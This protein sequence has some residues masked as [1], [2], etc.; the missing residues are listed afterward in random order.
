M[1]DVRL[2]IR[3]DSTAA[4]REIQALRREIAQ[5]Q[6]GL[7][8]SQRSAV[9]AGQAVDRLGDEARESAVGVTELGRSIFR[10]SAEAQA[11][12]RCVPRG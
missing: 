5:L 10:T 4:Q 1:A 6:Q 11:Y 9:G 8:Q 12:G 7:G 2:Q 3:A